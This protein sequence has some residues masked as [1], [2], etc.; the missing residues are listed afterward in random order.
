MM[1]LPDPRKFVEGL[2]EGLLQFVL[3]VIGSWLAVAVR[4]VRGALRLASDA[5]ALSSRTVL[6]IA[7]FV[8]GALPN[9]GVR[10]LAQ[11][12]QGGAFAPVDLNDPWST[13]YDQSGGL[14][15]YVTW[16]FLTFAIYEILSQF[17]AWMFSN[18]LDARRRL[19]VRMLR[20]AFA[21]MVILETLLFL[22][23]RYAKIFDVDPL[24]PRQFFLWMLLCYPLF[25]I[26]LAFARRMRRR[27]TRPLV[28]LL[29]IVTLFPIVRISSE[30]LVGHVLNPMFIPEV[31]ISVEALQCS[32]GEDGLHVEAILLNQGSRPIA[33]DRSLIGVRV[34]GPRWAP[35][36]PQGYEEPEKVL[37]PETMQ[38]RVREGEVMPQMLS[39]APGR[40][41]VL[42]P[43]GTL[44]LSAVAKGPL[45][46]KPPWPYYCRLEASAGKFGIRSA[47][48]PILREP[49]A[50]GG[51]GEGPAR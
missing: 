20:Y 14:W 23:L 30:N 12:F 2:I 11:A 1:Q 17:L 22:A 21:S 6:F 42:G 13:G 39:I 48:M 35:Y 29:V 5:Q 18:G 15:F 16:A 51:E 32:P 7:C 27:W 31:N 45:V 46:F 8:P 26:L 38:L 4:P 19:R 24:S 25:L 33:V 43:N 49:V 36:A 3:Q 9:F 47:N 44:R 28:A 40:L 10:N 41:E 37:D 34:I 50:A